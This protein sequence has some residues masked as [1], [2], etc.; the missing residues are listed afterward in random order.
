MTTTTE[1]ADRML[2]G[3]YT[4]VVRGEMQREEMPGWL[5]NAYRT[6]GAYLGRAHVSP[7]GPPFARFTFL[8]DLVAV[9][10]G[11]PVAQEIPG[12]GAVEPSTLPD[13]PAAVTTHFGRYEELEAAYQAVHRWLDDHGLV[14]ASPHWEIYFTDPHADPDPSTWRTDLVVPYRVS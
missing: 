4:A 1:I 10:A 7:T 9:E 3:Q 13:G 5:S 14:P 12:E 11:F 2:V 6:V 8:D